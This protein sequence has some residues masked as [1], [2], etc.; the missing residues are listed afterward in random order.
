MDHAIAALRSMMFPRLRNKVQ[1]RVTP[2]KAPRQLEIA[3]CLLLHN[4]TRLQGYPNK[5]REKK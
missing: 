2:L 3:S 4:D 5:S 1:V